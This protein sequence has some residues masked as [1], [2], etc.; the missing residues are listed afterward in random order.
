MATTKTTANA[1]DV[2]GT[3]LGKGET[4]LQLAQRLNQTLV[5]TDEIEDM[6]YHDMIVSLYR[7][8]PLHLEQQRL[9]EDSQKKLKEVKAEIKMVSKLAEKSEETVRNLKKL[10]AR[11]S[12]GANRTVSQMKE[13]LLALGVIS[14]NSTSDDIQ[15]AIQDE[16]LRMLDVAEKV[17]EIDFDIEIAEIE[18]KKYKDKEASFQEIVKHE[19]ESIEY[20]E[21]LMAFNAQMNVKVQNAYKKL[22]GIN[23][24]K[25]KVRAPNPLLLQGIPG[26]G[27]T[28][29]YH[30]AAKRVCSEFSLNYI[31]NVT[32]GYT[33]TRNDFVMVVQD[34]A[35]ETSSLILGGMPKTEEVEIHNQKRFVMTKAF[36][37]RFLSFELA[38]GGV[39][40]FDDVSNATSNIQN[41]L[42]PVMQSKSFSGLHIANC[43]MGATA[44]LGAI[45]QTHI[46]AMSAA[47]KTR[48]L[49]LLTGDKLDRFTKEMEEKFG[50]SLGTCGILGFLKHNPELFSLVP[51]AE[52]SPVARGFPCSR[53]YEDLIVTLRNSY[54]RF[55]GPGVGEKRLVAELDKVVSAKI[56]YEVGEEVRTYLSSYFSGTSELALKHINANDD[57]ALSAAKEEFKNFI[58]E[59]GGHGGDAMKAFYE[60]SESL[61]GH[62]LFKLSELRESS[63]PETRRDAL[64]IATKK[65][66]SSINSFNDNNFGLAISMFN[67][68]LSLFS[69]DYMEKQASGKISISH[70]ALVEVAGVFQKVP[71]ISP[72]KKEI[73][74]D[75]LSGWDTISNNVKTNLRA[76]RTSLM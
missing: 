57:E 13:D 48:M 38:A 73:L 60:F 27:K 58:N 41:M 4:L 64:A 8:E 11:E 72:T 67:H 68:R 61:V 75:L 22:T 33:P 65:F 23:F 74:S 69:S 43:L 36:N 55:G 54:L 66:A 70:S 76:G 26:Q 6:L 47:L 49:P 17:A 21:G 40:L 5:Y 35:G 29:V 32:D 12:F 46:H 51:S 24:D 18:V 30:S 20:W 14:E 7:K 42:L 59:K 50:D 45:D 2:L 37:K 10:K 16:R 63:N 53:T 25:D 31:K 9:Y 15:K 19:E 56:G 3:S 52:R 1:S 39:L 71:G 62:T 44:N 28:A 34:C